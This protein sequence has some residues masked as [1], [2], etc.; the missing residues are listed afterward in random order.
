MKKTIILFLLVTLLIVSMVGCGKSL[1]SFKKAYIKLPGG[2]EMTVNVKEWSYLDLRGSKMLIIDE[3]GD[4]YICS[5][6]NVTL[7]EDD[8]NVVNPY[9]KS[10][11]GD[12]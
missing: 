5:S 6:F 10:T 1:T 3:N 2:K 7:L 11:E 12:N 4:K 8:A 9:E